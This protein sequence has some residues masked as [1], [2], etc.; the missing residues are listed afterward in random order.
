MARCWACFTPPPTEEAAYGAEDSKPPAKTCDT[1]ANAESHKSSAD[2]NV[3]AAAP[4]EDPGEAR[5]GRPF[6]DSAFSP[7]AESFDVNPE[8]NDGLR[9]LPLDK[10]TEASGQGLPYPTAELGPPRPRCHDARVATLRA[11]NALDQP[12]EP[13]IEPI[14]ELACTVFGI[15]VA[16]VALVDGERVFIRNCFGDTSMVGLRPPPNLCNWTLVPSSHQVL[17]VEDT[18]L[19][20]RMRDH[21]WTQGGQLRFYCGAPLIAANNHRIGTLCIADS[22]PRTFDAERAMVMANMAELAVR[23]VEAAWAAEY[24]KSHATQLLR[25]LD[26]YEEAFMFV[27]ADEPL[28]AV[29]HVNEAAIEMTGVSRSTALKTAFW[30]LW[31]PAKSTQAPW[32]AYAAPVKSGEEFTICGLRRSHD[33]ST[34]SQ[35][36]RMSFRPAATHNVDA[37]T[38]PVGVPS[39]LPTSANMRR[40][41]FVQ[42]MREE[43]PLKSAGSSD[44][45][46]GQRQ[47]PFEDLR[48]GVLLG[49]GGYGR[50]Y[51]GTYKGELVAVKVI[52]D[53]TRV[54]MVNGVPL[55][56][57]LTSSLAHPNVVRLLE[58][59]TTGAGALAAAATA[60]AARKSSDFGATSVDAGTASAASTWASAAQ[61]NGHGENGRRTSLDSLPREEVWLLLEFCDRGTLAD[62]IDRG[63]F[64][65]VPSTVDGAPNCARIMSA[66]ADVAAGMAY[67]HARNVLH[68]DL[69]GGNVLLKS[70]GKG[71]QSFKAM[72]SDFGLA[73]D[74]DV[75][76]RLQT[77]TYGTITHMPP[78]LLLDDA[79]GKPG[80]VYAWGVLAWE[81]LAG[82][83][84]WAALNYGQVIHAVAIEGRALQVPATEPPE[85]GT[86]VARCLSRDPAARPTFKNIVAE[87]RGMGASAS[88]A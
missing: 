6:F 68:G 40:V 27:R 80:D 77:Q 31:K 36:L 12:P 62:G 19:D 57:S 7:V 10:Y 44:V 25:A 4:W 23:E 5:S 71:A 30:D 48:M 39:D 64:R 8:A 67:L 52:E 3:A 24:Q 45:V 87:L 54:R 41:F 53:A 63:L 55:E 35:T 42:I 9:K 17:V 50:V 22:M 46:V 72:V 70:I 28:W 78:E 58:Y 15:S 76:S 75:R 74:M 11:M 16:M 34:S 73:R 56:V 83:R 18:M 81:M 1:E 20:A 61:A 60:A 14:L 65:N 69:T 66:A 86:L 84:A 79:M 21:C 59:A 47:V 43:A 37:N 88:R 33:A 38:L 29:Q 13:N 32:E 51:C 49:A 85:F 26:C 2:Q 82:C